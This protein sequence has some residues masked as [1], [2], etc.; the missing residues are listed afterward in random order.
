MLVLDDHNRHAGR[1]FACGQVREQENITALPFLRMTY[2]ADPDS[3][4]G[5]AFLEKM[6]ET[7]EK[8]SQE[9]KGRQG[10]SSKDLAIRNRR[11]GPI[12]EAFEATP[13][14]KT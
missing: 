9:F 14:R 13:R 6:N 4:D 2:D 7:I 11:D 12:R 8:L 1:V 3:A 5:L 10:S